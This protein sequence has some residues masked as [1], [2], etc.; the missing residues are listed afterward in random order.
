M[1][2]GTN[3]LNSTGLAVVLP[4]IWSGKKINDFYRANLTAANHFTDMSDE[5]AIEGDV[6]HIPN[7][8]APSASAKTNGSQVTLANPTETEVQLTVSSWYESS[9][10]I[11]DREAKQVL[12]SW[13][14]QERM[15]RDLAYACAKQLD[16]AILALYSGL[17]T[18]VGAS[19][20]DVADSIILAAISELDVDDVPA[21]GRRFFFYPSVF[22]KDLMGIA[23]FY[24]ASTLGVSN[25]PVRGGTM[26]YI[27]GIPV[28]VSSNVPITAS[29]FVHNMLAHKDA[30]VFATKSLDGRKEGGVRMQANYV[31]EYLGTLMTADVVYG[32]AENRD[33]G[34]VEIRSAK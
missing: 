20:T 8:T 30:F 3:H 1:A 11:E 13:G 26:P 10:L 23:K 29:T 7:T 33:S 17:S 21:D 15:V 25:G 28:T 9:K 18:N 31:P 4:D 5:V 22:W 6:L 34:A 19:T 27:Y 2:L 24:D 16:T 14:R 32:V 12:N